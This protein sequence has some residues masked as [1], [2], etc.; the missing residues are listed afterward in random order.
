MTA[1]DAS[2]SNQPPAWPKGIGAPAQRALAAAGYHRLEDLTAVTEA[3]LAKLHGMGPKALGVL[4]EALAAR[5][6]SFAGAAAPETMDDIYNFIRI[7]DRT[8]TGGMP[9]AEQLRA[10][11][12]A[13]VTAVINLATDNPG[14]SLTGEAQLAHDLGL[15]YI[16]IQVDWGNPTDE[17]FAAFE[18]AMTQRP[19]AN[20]LIHCA[21]NYRVTAFYSLYARRYLGWTEAQAAELRDRIWA[22]SDYPVWQ[23]F[24]A[25][26]T[27]EHAA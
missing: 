22:G 12:A 23:A 25:R 6:L 11:A 7:D 10:A 8:A 5:G 24:I 20:L 3:D 21:A 17:D 14:H 1:A 19:V 18:D 16:H 2:S 13:G 27:T 26:K 9:T 4:H 15:E